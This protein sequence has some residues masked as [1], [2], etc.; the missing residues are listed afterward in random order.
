MLC[1]EC[2]NSPS[3]REMRLKVDTRIEGNYMEKISFYFVNS[4]YKQDV[5]NKRRY[6]NG[7]VQKL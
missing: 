7:F 5:K 4:T 2:A 1:A 6:V 3:T